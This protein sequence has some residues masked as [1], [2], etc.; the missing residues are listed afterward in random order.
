[1]PTFTARSTSS[2]PTGIHPTPIPS[3]TDTRPNSPTSSL[4]RHPNYYLPGDD[5]FILVIDTLFRV[6][7]YF[8]VRES[9]RWL[10]LL[11]NTDL[12][13][14]PHNPV[15]LSTEFNINP[16]STPHTFALLLWVFYNPYYYV[17]DTSIEDLWD[18]EVYATHWEMQNV[19]SLIDQELHRLIRIHRRQ[20]ADTS[21]HTLSLIIDTDSNATTTPNVVDE[22]WE[23]AETPY[24]EWITDPDVEEEISLLLNR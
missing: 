20:Q 4:L 3:P 7:S 16:P 17:F 13:R 11:R 14:N 2:S 9:T 12:G 19:L 18:I 24:E 8:F 6:H 5:L 1:M 23:T 21:W 22:V 15:V 10:H